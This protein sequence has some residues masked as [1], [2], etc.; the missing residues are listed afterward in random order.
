MSFR[1]RTLIASGVGAA[2]LLVGATG[3][4]AA[5]LEQVGS[6]ASPVYV[7]SDPTDEDRIFVVEQDGRIKLTSGGVTTTFLDLDPIVLSAGEPGQPGTGNERGL[8]SMAFALDYAQSGR[9]YVFYTG[10]DAGTLH[11]DELTASGDTADPAS[12]RQVL[13]IPHADADNHN[14]GQLQFGPDGYLY[15]S[16]GDGGAGQ[17]ANAQLLGNLLGKILRID[18]QPGG[19]Y[20]VP[21]GNPFGNEI[22]SYGLRNPWRFSFDRATGD[23]LI[24]DVGE[25]AWEEV[26]YDPA[27]TGAGFGD[28]FGWDCRE[29]F[30]AGPGG[31]GGSFTEPVLA[32]ANDAT[33]CAVTGGYVVR[34][35]GLD[36]LQGRYVYADFC[37]DTVR[38][39]VPATPFALGDR[40]EGLTVLRPTSFGEDACGRVYVASRDGPVYRLV[41]GTPTECPVPET[42]A[43]PQ[44]ELKGKKKQSMEDTRRVSV[45]ASA[46]DTATVALGGAVVAGRRAK[47]LFELPDS[48]AQLGFAAT[49]KVKLKLSGK[50]A[51]RVRHRIR[52]GKR[53]EARIQGVATDP[54]GKP[55]PP[56]SFETRLVLD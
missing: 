14:G 30:A 44:L 54:A 52:N 34:D 17:S 16:T 24:A 51:R 12:R 42:A 53:V 11:V 32:Y 50:E 10:T 36:E 28:N 8:L 2:T 37:G 9:F 27:V 25:G 39:F 31:C 43:G 33:N 55:G 22:W 18:P 56:A 45:K 5:S 15:V 3:A 40:S 48:S 38:S 19:G 46:S 23:L 4:H 20:L 13:A 35:P 26:D 7:T 49:E 41:D 21:P 29:A 1:Y 47:E 6:Y